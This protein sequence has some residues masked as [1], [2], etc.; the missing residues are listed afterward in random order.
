VLKVDALS[1][2]DRVEGVMEVMKHLTGPA[3][4]KVRRVRPV[5]RRCSQI[6]YQTLQEF[7]GVSAEDFELIKRVV[8]SGR[9]SAK[10]K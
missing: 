5:T 10:P 1:Y 2:S 9:L 4:E 7:G 3:P 8:D 6:A